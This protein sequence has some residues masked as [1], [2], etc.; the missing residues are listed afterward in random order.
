[1]SRSEEGLR[2]PS[3][4]FPV[5]VGDDHVLRAEV[6]VV[7]TGGLDDDEAL[8]SVD[9]RG[10]AEG[11]EDEAALDEFQ[12]GFEDLGAEFFE[13]HGMAFGIQNTFIE[14]LVVGL[15]GEAV[16]WGL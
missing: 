11:V 5:E 7:D 3:T 13:E 10:V 14:Y 16:T 8:L 4:I 9:T 6:V 12:V 2:A 1:M 15:Q